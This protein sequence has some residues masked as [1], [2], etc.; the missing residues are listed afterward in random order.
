MKDNRDIGS[1][2]KEQARSERGEIEQ[3]D[4]AIDDTEMRDEEQ[5]AQRRQHSRSETGAGE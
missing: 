1:E 4:Q 3:Q 2:T 5:H